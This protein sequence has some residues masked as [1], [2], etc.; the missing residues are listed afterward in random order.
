MRTPLQVLILE[1]RAADAE[2]MLHEL[3]RAGFEPEWRCVDTE[4]DY[5]AQLDHAPDI[6]LADYSLPQFDGLTAH[7]L[8]QKYGLDIP[9]ILVSGSIGE[10]AAVSAMKQGVA[11]YI[12]KDRMTRLGQ[13]VENALESKKLRQAK[14]QAEAE[15]LLKNLVFDASIAANSIADLNDVITQAN[16]AFLRLWGYLGIQ[17]VIGKKLSDFLLNQDESATIVSSLTDTGQWEGEYIAKRKD[18]STFIAYGLATVVREMS[19]KIIGY[20]SSVIDVTK[21]KLALEEIQHLAKFPSENPSPV[22]RVTYDGTLLYANASSHRLLSLWGCEI[23]THLP[24]DVRHMISEVFT[25]DTNTEIEVICGDTIYSLLFA[26]IVDEGYAN[27]YGQ[28]IT[29]R[30]RADEELRLT[31]VALESVANG[32]VITDVAGNI[33]WVNPA[34]TALTGYSK[35]ESR[36]RNPRELVRSG[37]HDRVFYKELWDTIL[38]GQ[39]WRGELINRRKDGSLYTEEQS[40]T[41]VRNGAGKISHFIAIKQDISDRKRA[42]AALTQE[43]NLLRTLIDNLPDRIYAKDAEGRFSLKNEA[44]ARQMGAASTAEVIGKTDFDYYPLEIAQ[45]YHADD[46]SVLESGQ[47]LIDREELFVDVHGNQGWMLTSKVPLRDNHG[48]VIGLVGIGR[49]ITERKR[50]EKAANEAERFAHSALDALSA[51]IAI[52]DETGAILAVNQAWVDF[53]RA[54]SAIPNSRAYQGENYLEVCDLATGEDSEEANQVAAGIRTVLRGEK[55]LFELEYPCHSPT[56]RRWFSVKVTRFQGE[57][58]V[59]VVVA[60]ENITERK[61]AA[62]ELTALYNATSFLYKADS[63]LNL[64]HQIAQA[65]VSEFSQADCGV[66][67]VD[68]THNS[69]LRLARAGSYGVELTAP[70]NLDDPSLV[71]K[72]VQTG[73]PIYAPD[74]RESPYYARGDTR[75]LS[76][77][78]I[79]LHFAE[80]I[81]GVLD[82][83]SNKLDAFSQ[84]DQRVLKVFSERAAAALQIMRLYEELNLRAAEL[85]WRVQERTAQLNHSKNHI[86]SILNSSSDIIILCR[87]NGTISQVNPAFDQAFR[88]QPDELLFQPLT[89]LVI[90]PLISRLEGAFGRALATQQSQRLELTVHYKEQVSFEVDVVLSPVVEA[91]GK[92]QGVVCSLR[93]IT[94]RKQMENQIH[95]MLEKAMRLSELKTRYVAMAAH[96]LR[97]PLAVIQSSA[98]IIRNHSDRLTDGQRQ[99]QFDQIQSQIIMMVAMLDDILTLGRVESGKLTFN[100]MTLDLIAFCQNLAADVQLASGTAHPINLLSQGFGKTADV[101]VKLLRHI[102]GNLLSNAIK[103]SPEQSPVTFTVACE[104][105]QIVFC[106]QDQGIGIPH[107]EQVRLFEA[108]HRASNAKQI[109]G[110]GLGLAIVK[111]S[112]DLHGGTITFESEEGQGTTFTVTLPHANK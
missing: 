73:R 47:P 5:L 58:P 6:I 51:H 10:E 112:V 75:T 98:N 36:G 103:Y 62:S 52:L 25:A 67:L 78:V 79:P 89:S 38:A 94:V 11:D 54:N 85:E 34:F 49:D 63:L 43:R 24:E 60:H 101:D 90:P 18:G 22:L 50:A 8:L 87:N 35:E 17:E 13:A 106:I 44:D 37:L 59:R 83:Q 48:Q 28:D 16:P 15:L 1:D 86:E 88:C 84:K 109:P 42:E 56:E 19:G 53:A 46:Q 45:Q 82:L 23:G 26:P 61:E 66:L 69:M 80:G 92:P 107:N 41:P 95:Q 64:G 33:E 12:L 32:V 70:L 3:R 93:D 14:R 110:T 4:A 71:A 96:D 65:V 2:L 55:T 72:A 20:Q 91:D 97:N 21:Q 102:L 7:R 77:L 104:P 29:E 9:F 74:V 76:E 27:I 40:I 111:Q 30:K 31:S 68:K 100:P 39:V 105:D 108:F 57:G 81:I 99:T